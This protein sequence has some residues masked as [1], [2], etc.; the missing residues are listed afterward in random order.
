[1]IQTNETLMA[2]APQLIAAA[3]AE[4]DAWDESDVDTYAGGGICHIIAERFCTVLDGAG[5]ECV[6]TC[7]TMEQ[8][9]Y[10][11]A[12]LQDGVYEVDLPYR[13]YEVGGGFSWTKL[14]DVTFT[15]DQLSVFRLD[16]D[17]ANFEMYYEQ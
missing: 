9:V 13:H 8:H 7:S 6:T 4:Y 16:K 2:L 5:I 11:V 10:V 12:K 3:Q 1:M 15:P 17:P 14:P